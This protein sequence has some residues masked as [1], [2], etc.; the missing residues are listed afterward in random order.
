MKMREEV[1][2]AL[3]AVFAIFMI[4][5]GVVV[6]MVGCAQVCEC[7]QKPAAKVAAKGK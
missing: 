2:D 1:R 4:A 3:I 7:K 5:T 6:G